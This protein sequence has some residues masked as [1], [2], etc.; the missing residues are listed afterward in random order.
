[1][2]TG[3]SQLTQLTEGDSV[4]LSIDTGDS[5]RSENLR[6]VAVG[7]G[8]EPE[9]GVDSKSSFIARYVE[10]PRFLGLSRGLSPYGNKGG[11]RQLQRKK[12]SRFPDNSREG[13]PQR[14]L[15]HLPVPQ[16]M[17]VSLTRQR[18]NVGRKWDRVY[19]SP[20]QSQTDHDQARIS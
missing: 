11:I 8:A 16:P 17:T 5:Q 13:S 10:K 3:S 19:L 9:L 6:H 4:R 2:A 12:S 18:V 1:M 14:G 15:G 7:R 20:A